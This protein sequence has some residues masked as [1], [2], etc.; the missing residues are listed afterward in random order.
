MHVS[1]VQAIITLKYMVK[2]EDDV[3]S[4]RNLS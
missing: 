2:G 4:F 3:L 1:S